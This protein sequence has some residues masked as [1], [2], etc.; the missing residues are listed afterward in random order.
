MFCVCVREYVA[1]DIGINDAINST[2]L[3]FRITQNLNLILFKM[4]T[5]IIWFSRATWAEW[6]EMRPIFMAVFSTKNK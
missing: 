3:L 4:V 2:S 1:R 6:F 5:M